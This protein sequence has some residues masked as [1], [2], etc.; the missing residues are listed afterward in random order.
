MFKSKWII[1]RKSILGK[2]M[3][4]EM[5]IGIQD[6]GKSS[7][8]VKNMALRAFKDI[9]IENVMEVADIGAGRGELTQLLLPL[10][11]K[12]TMVDFFNAN[13]NHTKINFVQA[14]LNQNWDI[15]NDTFDF[16]FSLEV[17]E[18]IENPR[19]FIREIARVLKNGGSGF[20][21]T[22]NNLNLFSKLYFLVKN[23]HRF[24]QDYCYPAHITCLFKKDMER[25]LQEN[26]FSLKKIYYNYEDVLPFLGKNIYIRSKHF[27]NSIGF[28][29]QKK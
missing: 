10:V 4:K 25:I 11:N 13:L 26:N 22:P 29:F 17:I 1:L 6:E 15:P 16:V 19:H 24:F 3:D 8:S 27:S 2:T 9:Q 21:S 28:L 23:E 14:D 5:S 12:V 18:H 7:G 20:I